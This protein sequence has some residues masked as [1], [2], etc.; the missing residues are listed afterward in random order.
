MRLLV[1][2]AAIL[3]EAWSDVEAFQSKDGLTPESKKKPTDVAPESRVL[4][5]EPLAKPLIRRDYAPGRGD[6]AGFPV[7][8]RLFPLADG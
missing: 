6:S 3:R 1:P 5:L 4:L 2:P 8:L 7:C